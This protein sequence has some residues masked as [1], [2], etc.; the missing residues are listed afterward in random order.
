MGSRAR[1][2]P[3]SPQETILS[4]WFPEFTQI[5]ARPETPKNPNQAAILVRSYLFR[6]AWLGSRLKA[7]PMLTMRTIGQQDYSVRDDGQP[8]GRIRYASERRP[9]IW[10]IGTSA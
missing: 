10:M 5:A 8:I 4:Q 6:R 7:D 3:R 2:P 1:V 9:G